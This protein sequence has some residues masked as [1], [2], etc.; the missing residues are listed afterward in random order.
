[1]L[2]LSTNAI[3]KKHKN[4]KIFSHC[5]CLQHFL[6]APAFCLLVADG[7]HL[8]WEQ[9]SSTHVSGESC[10][11]QNSLSSA[12][13]LLGHN[14]VGDDSMWVKKL[15][16]YSILLNTSKTGWWLEG[17]GQHPLNNITRCMLS[18]PHMFLMCL[19]QRGEQFEENYDLRN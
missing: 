14:K 7:C 5:K 18:P 9:F 4:H 13:V 15:C 8:P 1:M 19:Y 2:F 11:A 10:S 16:F 12:G 3:E 17:E 6:T